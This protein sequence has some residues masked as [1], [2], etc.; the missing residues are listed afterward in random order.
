MG[1]FPTSF[2]FSHGSGNSYFQLSLDTNN[3]P[4]FY[5]LVEYVNFF[6]TK[7]VQ[8]NNS[9]IFRSVEVIIF[10]KLLKVIFSRGST[11]KK[12]KASL[13]T[14]AWEIRCLQRSL[15]NCFNPIG[16]ETIV[17][18]AVEAVVSALCLRGLVALRLVSIP[19]QEGVHFSSTAAW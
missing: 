15:R 17:S 18:R 14:P 16:T 6:Q 9:L 10:H 12:S 8:Y 13:I 2:F 4:F 1:K 3:M 19:H 5:G 7:C 11:Q